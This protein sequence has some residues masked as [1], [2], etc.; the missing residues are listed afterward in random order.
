MFATDAEAYGRR[1]LAA[2]PDFLL[3]PDAAA[4]RAVV[5]NEPLLLTESAGR[6]L[7]DVAESQRPEAD[8]EIM[9]LYE[10]SIELLDFCR[11]IGVDLAF[12]WLVEGGEAGPDERELFDA[13]LALV[14]ASSW[15]QVGDLIR[16]RAPLRDVGADAVLARL[17]TAHPT[18]EPLPAHALLAQ[19]RQ[20]LAWCRDDGVTEALAAAEAGRAVLSMI[21]AGPSTPALFEAATASDDGFPALVEQYP[22]LVSDDFDHRLA[23][24]IDELNGRDERSLERLLRTRFLLI[25]CQEVPPPVALAEVGDTIG[26]PPAHPLDDVFLTLPPPVGDVFDRAVADH[27]ELLSFEADLRL[28]FHAARM[29]TFNR[30]DSAAKFATLRRALAFQRERASGAVPADAGLADATPAR[31]PDYPDALQEF[32]S[33]QD[34]VT[35]RSV[36]EAHPELLGD[37]V[38]ALL[39]DEVT[40]LRAAQAAAAH[41]LDAYRTLFRWCRSIGVEAAFERMTNAGRQAVEA[42]ER[43]EAAD[44][45][46]AESGD[47]AHLDVVVDARR[48]Q[49]DLAAW[50]T[51]PVG[52]INDAALLAAA[53][54]KRYWA[55][56]RPADLDEGRT[57]LQAVV[58]SPDTE[59]ADRAAAR[60]NLGIVLVER[61]AVTGESGDA[62]AAVRNF[63]DLL[64]TGEADRATVEL[65][66]TTALL[67]LLDST[68]DVASLDEA[69]ERL[70]PLTRAPDFDMNSLF[71][72]RY[73][74]ATARI[75]RYEV[76]G[77]DDD[78]DLAIEFAESATRTSDIPRDKVAGV[79]SLLSTG[80]S[81]RHMRDGRNDDISRSVDAAQAAVDRVPDGADKGLYRANLGGRLIDRYQLTRSPAD[82][83]EA[84]EVLSAAIAAIPE[85]APQFPD[86]LNN[87][88]LAQRSRYNLTRDPTDLDTAIVTRRRI[89][90]IERRDRA[91]PTPLYLDNL[92]LSL[93]D[94]YELSA[95]PEDL[96]ESIELAREAVELSNPSSARR[97]VYAHHL[98]TALAARWR[99]T[100]AAADAEEATATYRESVA[101]GARHSAP[102]TVDAARAWCGFAA[103]REAWAEAA[104][105]ADHLV[106]G[107][108]AGFRRQLSAEG[109]QLTLRGIQ[110]ASGEA[111]YAHARDGDLAKAVAVLE[112]GQAMMLAEALRE[113]SLMDGLTDAGR[114]DL[115]DRYRRAVHRL[116]ALTGR[117]MPASSAR[118]VADTTRQTR[119]LDAAQA[120]LSAL[121]E[122]IRAVPGMGPV[123]DDLTF[124]DIHD[125]AG[126]GTA[127]LYCAT[128]V[129]GGLALLVLPGQP[130]VVPWFYNLTYG[131]LRASLLDGG[132]AAGYL[133]GV[134]GEP[135][136]LGA[137]LPGLLDVLRTTVGEPLARALRAAS[138]SSVTIVPTGVMSMM[139]VHAALTGE[140]I[141]VSYAPSARALR[142]SRELAR[143]LGDRTPVF[144]GVQ[145]PSATLAFAP[146][147]MAE[148]D[149]LFADGS[150]TVLSDPGLRTEDL[151]DALSQGATHV[152]FA[153]HGLY[154]PDDPLS[155]GIVLAG[156]RRLRIGDLRRGPAAIGRLVVASACQTAVIDLARLPDEV[157]S[158]PT[159]LLASGAAGVLG[160]LWPVEDLSTALLVSRFYQVL[161]TGVTPAAAL[162]TART[163]LATVTAADLATHFGAL[164]EAGDPGLAEVAAEAWARF[165]LGHQPDDRPFAEPLYW[166]PFILVGS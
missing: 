70:E 42:R 22:D 71:I 72:A 112:N 113:S 142:T 73:N 7:R 102:G 29:R 33:A 2:L 96:A 48:T 105:A 144:L 44:D 12:H 152:H 24:T 11:V 160:T 69:V 50:T 82:V 108:S 100:G 41:E 143:R 159:A 68:G 161:L 43:A 83:D 141:D 101:D 165:H 27:P 95:R 64:E 52:Q 104:E 153:C 119:A 145:D 124:D 16:Q 47:P 53:L 97:P 109:K 84:I 13:V 89:V 51:T 158:L 157:M 131:Q 31:S 85:T 3:A 138:L 156:R 91:H 36:L 127:I 77:E 150:A 57:L 25:R 94:R 129:L 110:G 38:D 17:A 88:G 136:E 32:I 139:P 151:L 54:I 135:E 62:D 134:L 23:L 74:Y 99:A 65:N 40:R 55:R 148:T 132:S 4:M 1:I 8:E 9:R 56:S 114:A 103:E 78:L 98:A 117:S 155:S 92:G 120:E 107:L 20:F 46:Y 106:R 115:A 111:A 81:L 58:D 34:W 76:Y 147:E 166:A 66:L 140:Q 86:R 128:T 80:L 39:G 130:A 26:E 6:I 30:D 18:I 35:A 125:L 15:A 63:R 75:T 49:L 21:D 154:E 90:D 60:A 10:K 37:E 162:R 116:D 149:K 79:Y 163:W 164:A 123:V 61:Y 87:L 45:A 59:P 118:P 146:L 93:R 133:R 19:C 14:R 28:G 122:E 137:A 126:D 121:L 5:L 67:D